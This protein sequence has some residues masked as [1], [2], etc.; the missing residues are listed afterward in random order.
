MDWQQQYEIIK[1][2]LAEKLAQSGS[3]FTFA[4]AAQLLG[5]KVPKI[6]AWAKG[7][8]PTGDD[9]ETLARVLELSADWLLLGYGTPTRSPDSGSRIKE[10]AEICDT[11]NEISHELPDGLSEIA[12]AGGISLTELNDI[13]RSHALP[14]SLTVARW[15]HAYRINAN[16]LLA[17]VGQPYLTESEYAASGPADSLREY[18]GDF[19]SPPP[20]KP[21]RNKSATNLPACLPQPAQAIPVLGLA[22]CGVDGWEQPMQIAASTTIPTISDT[23]V[24]V[25]ASGDSMLPAGIASGHICLCD[26]EQTAIPG[27]AV[28]VKRRDGLATIKLFLG[29][30]EH[31]PDWVLLKGWLSAS[32]NNHRKEFYIDMRA[33]DVETMA[34]VIY[35]RRRI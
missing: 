24:A 20:K 3:K 27:D 10:F 13:L 1:K 19:T 5:V 23:T 29:E 35:V 15:I 9:L 12:H 33:G 26:P 2:M 14:S 16:F 18:R 28:L 4:N 8:R 25:I 30:G 31:G 21:K 17:Q 22:S 6:Q 32:G 34:P 11:L 7:Q